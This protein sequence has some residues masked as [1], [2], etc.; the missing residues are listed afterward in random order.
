MFYIYFYVFVFI[1]M[2]CVLCGCETWFLT[3]RERSVNLVENS[4]L[5]NV[6]C[7]EGIGLCEIRG[8]LHNEKLDD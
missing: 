3:L 2:T 7:A 1:F 5:K 4:L 8:E 6:F